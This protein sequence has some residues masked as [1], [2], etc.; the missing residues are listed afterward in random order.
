MLA[1]SLA[2]AQ[3]SVDLRT[4]SRN[5]DFSTA[6]STRPVKTGSSL[7]A[8]C[9][10]GELFFL[11]SGSSGENLYGCTATN[12]WTRQS[13]A[14]GLPPMAGHANKVLSTDGGSASWVA[15]GGDVS[16]PASAMTVT[17]LQGRTVAAIAPADGQALIW[18]ATAGQWQPAPAGTA[19]VVAGQG[20]TVIQAGQQSTISVDTA[21]VPTFLTVTT[22]LDFSP[23]WDG[24]CTSST[25]TFNGAA[26]GDGLAAGWP[27]TLEP[28]LVGMMRVSAANTVEV[29]L[30]NWSGATV[31]P[32]S[33]PFR[34]TLV[35]GF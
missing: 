20:V 14:S 26:T 7:P 32:A 23:I 24:C 21:A 34:A 22:V 4:Q 11:S 15:A 17:R 5:V 28:G 8:I 9:A 30:C 10:V 27:P 13:A 31:D 16:G 18:N 2:Q 3:T 6:A 25:F 1:A 35:R 33:Q 29:K 19:N 12:T